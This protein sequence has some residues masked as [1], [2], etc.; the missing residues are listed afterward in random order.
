MGL[1]ISIDKIKYTMKS[2]MTY[3]KKSIRFSLSLLINKLL[4]LKLIDESFFQ[5]PFKINFYFSNIILSES[6]NVE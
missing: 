3:N 1:A 2:N 5:R 6:N 4:A